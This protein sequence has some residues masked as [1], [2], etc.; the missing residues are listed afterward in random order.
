[1]RRQ[2][3]DDYYDDEDDAPRSRVLGIAS[4]MA[5]VFAL[6]GFIWLAWHAYMS[7]S[8]TYD[9]AEA[10][11]VKAEATPYKEVPQDPGGW[12]APHR[13]KTI[14]EVIDRGNGQKTPNV[15]EHLSAAPEEPMEVP[16]PSAKKEGSVQ[17]GS[18]STWMNAKLRDDGTEIP[19][20]DA[21]RQ[22]VL[23][24]EGKQPVKKET[25]TAPVPAPAATQAT[26]APT[27][28]VITDDELKPVPAPV[29]TAPKVAT[30]AKAPVAPAAV[31]PVE[32]ASGTARIQ[33]GA[34]RTEVE[35]AAH[36]KHLGNRV[37][38]VLAGKSTTVERADLG[39]K[40]IY[41]R[42]F[43]LGFSKPAATDAC[44]RIKA[45]RLDCLVK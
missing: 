5:G 6:V 4:L 1:M 17:T 25:V 24:E 36:V 23:R 19:L 27:T 13:D 21:E 20:T 8:T 40:G 16:A 42:L 41:Y 30:P 10:E 39:E 11:L 45:A 43:A 35:A 29:A 44:A 31:K 14:Y 32:A 22:K 9:P 37:P 12:Q 7:G 28:P 2:H 34:F 38:G 18:S 15:A 3:D 26:A 33:L